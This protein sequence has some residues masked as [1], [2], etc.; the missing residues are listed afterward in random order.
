MQ[1]YEV[2]FTKAKKAQELSSRPGAH[3]SRGFYRALR[4]A[5]HYSGELVKQNESCFK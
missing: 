2:D 4:S 5:E 1:Y 3:G